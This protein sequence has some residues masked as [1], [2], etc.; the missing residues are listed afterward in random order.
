MPR[1]AA[2]PSFEFSEGIR[3]LRREP[4]WRGQWEDYIESMII[5]RL[6][7][8]G[9]PFLVTLTKHS[10]YWYC[11]GEFSQALRSKIRG[12]FE[13]LFA[14]E[15]LPKFV[16][17]HDLRESDMHPSRPAHG[18]LAQMFYDRVWVANYSEKWPQNYVVLA[19]PFEDKEEIKELGAQFDLVLR[20]WR[21]R[22]RED[23]SAFERWLPSRHP[24]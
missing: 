9:E 12:G 21:V 15:E 2:L 11:V 16:V 3:I 24:R 4:T 23:M 6:T 22:W 14:M 7:D 10:V 18:Q 19:V 13:N 17:S 1:R 20:R 8:S 5:G